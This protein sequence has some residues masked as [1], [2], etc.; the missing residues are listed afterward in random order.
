VPWFVDD[1]GKNELV[2]IAFDLLGA[3]TPVT[4]HYDLSE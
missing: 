3:E 4:G 2:F 1:H